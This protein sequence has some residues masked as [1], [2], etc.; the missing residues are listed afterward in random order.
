MLYGDLISFFVARKCKK[1]KKL[2]KIANIDREIRH[3][4]RM[5]LGISIQFS[6]NMWPIIILKVT[7]KKGFTLPL[8]DTFSKKSQGRGQI[9]SPSILGVKK[10]LKLS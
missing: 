9:D 4:F 5:T 1:S 7:K 3:I 2:M 10:L 6:R 8:E